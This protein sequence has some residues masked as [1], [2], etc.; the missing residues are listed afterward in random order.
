M[1]YRYGN[2]EQMTFLPASVEEYVGANDPVR[3]YDAFI[4]AID[5]SKLG[6]ELN[7]KKIGNSSYYPL[8]MFKLLLFGISYGI[9]SSRH[10]ERALYHNLAF[11]WLMGNLKPDYKTISEFRRNNK[12]A[13]R[14]LLKEC[15]RL[16]ME[17]G[18]IDGN[19]LF[20]DGTKIRANAGIKHNWNKKRCDRVLKKIDTRIDSIL[21]ECERID[22]DESQSGSL[23]EMREE[24]QDKKERKKK[25]ENFVKQMEEKQ[26]KNLNTTDGDCTVIHGIQGSH[27]GY[28][29][30]SVVDK[31]HGL[32]VNVDVVTE[33]NDFNQLSK[34]ITQANATLGKKCEV[35]CADS[36]YTNV[37][38][39]KKVKEAGIR[40][41]APSKTQA[42]KKELSPFDKA[43]FEFDH[44]KD[45]YICPEGNP[46]T[47]VTINKAKKCTVYQIKDGATCRNCCHFNTC[48]TN[49][50][51]R[52]VTRL[53]NED[54]RE[55]LE[56]EYKKPESQEIYKLR[57]EKV[58]L[59]FGHIKHNLKMT[60]FLLRGLS[61]VNAE[62]SLFANSFNI[63][64][65]V[66]I[67]GVVGLVEKLSQLSG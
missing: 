36:G 53:F 10:L 35:A 16:C 64:R 60:G 58:E 45:C 43:Q 55:E 24:L 14:K 27:A 37:D 7:S 26:V 1:A 33:N 4:E 54:V 13:L 3:A 38:D 62:M 44:E 56:G 11:M 6:I 34:Q 40:V 48:T 12:A 66:N 52:K 2:R 61:G 18:L 15:A 42:S 8:S 29:A 21:S 20:V 57:K 39:I 32:I 23:V 47:S 31:K 41:V 5:F 67:F 25:I 51:G 9:T 28:N 59:P 65:M 46:L 63:V 22:A 19:I 30:Q 49:K 17:L 50:S